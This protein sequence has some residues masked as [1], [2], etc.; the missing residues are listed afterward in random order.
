[1]GN[2]AALEA[3][4]KQYVIASAVGRLSALNRVGSITTAPCTVK[5]APG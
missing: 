4:G 2:R 3:T 1:M 5:A